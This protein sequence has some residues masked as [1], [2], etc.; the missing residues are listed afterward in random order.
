M[1]ILQRLGGFSPG[2]KR[3]LGRYCYCCSVNNGEKEARRKAKDMEKRPRMTG[4]AWWEFKLNC[5]SISPF[6]FLYLA[7]KRKMLK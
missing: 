5:R 3:R 6:S 7:P 2:R 4:G 1:T